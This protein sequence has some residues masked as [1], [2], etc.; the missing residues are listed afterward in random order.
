MRKTDSE[1]IRARIVLIVEDEFL[2]RCALADTLRDAGC[3]VV[4]AASADQAMS[5]R[6]EGPQIDVLITDIQLDGQSSGWE[7]AEAFRAKSENIPVIY[8]SGNADDRARCVPNSL[9]FGKPYRPA[10]VLR[11]CQRLMASNR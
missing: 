8:T 6:R 10:E 1:Y 2:L 7:I 4:E 3:V 9:F 11:A 5:L